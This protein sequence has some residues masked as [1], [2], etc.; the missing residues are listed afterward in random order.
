MFNKHLNKAGGHI[1]CKFNPDCRRITIQ[2]Y[3]TLV[4]GYGYNRIRTGDLPP[5]IQ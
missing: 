2:E 1:S 3:L 5:W 4:P